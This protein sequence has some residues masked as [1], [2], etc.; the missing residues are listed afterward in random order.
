M[1]TPN[2]SVYE[3]DAW[4]LDTRDGLLQRDGETIPLTFKAFEILLVL[5]QNS[6][7]L[8]EKSYFLERVWPNTFVDEANLTQNIFRLRKI[9]GKTETGRAYIETVPKRGYRFLADVREV[10]NG[11]IEA[12][13]KASARQSLGK[14]IG[15]AATSDPPLHSLAILPLDSF[16]V[17]LDTQYLADG[18]TETII[19]SLSQLCQVRIMA[20]STMAR[21][22]HKGYDILKVG[23]KLGVE[24]GLV[25][26]LL[27]LDNKL[28]VRVE[29]VDIDRGWQIWGEQYRRN[30]SDLLTV[31]EDI[32]REVSEKLR[33]KLIGEETTTHKTALPRI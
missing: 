16:A 22:R 2:K 1:T 31:Q 28:I 19:N 29:L 25:G 3:F 10:V 21:Y 4:A 8:V 17:D 6:H 26:K 33:L 27:V 15:T 13:T 7:H 18:I 5:I 11:G 14:Y 24:F 23:R 32:S 9:L 20:W 30:L 12:I